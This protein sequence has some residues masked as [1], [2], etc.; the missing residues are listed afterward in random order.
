[1]PSSCERYH[2]NQSGKGGYAG[3]AGETGAADAAFMCVQNREAQ[4]KTDLKTK[5][6]S[7]ATCVEDRLSS[8]DFYFRS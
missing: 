6:I 3:G 1:M 8:F 2:G 7:W 4:T 5:T